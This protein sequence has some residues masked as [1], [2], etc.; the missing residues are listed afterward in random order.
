MSIVAFIILGAAVE[1]PKWE[2]TNEKWEKTPFV[3]NWS[4]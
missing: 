3:Q 4:M 2:Q 1:N